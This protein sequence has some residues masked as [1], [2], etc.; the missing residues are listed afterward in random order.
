MDMLKVWNIKSMHNDVYT[1]YYYLMDLHIDQI[2]NGTH[3]CKK[4][5]KWY[6][7][8]NDMEA[9]LRLLYLQ[10]LFI[11]EAGL[12]ES[13]A[14]EG[15]QGW[16]NSTSTTEV[17]TRFGSTLVKLKLNITSLPMNGRNEVNY[18]LNM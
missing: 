14:P 3:V 15:V 10:W 4:I 7:V 11:Q 12:K 9:R 6:E 1:A 16:R 8:T 18:A 2:C 5:K 17:I 13:R